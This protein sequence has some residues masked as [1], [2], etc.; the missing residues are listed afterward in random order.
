MLI[1]LQNYFTVDVVYLWLN[2][3]VL[4]LWL[5]LIFFPNSRM[6]KI[7]I[8]SI[9]MPIVFSVTYAYITYIFIIQSDSIFEISNFYFGI[10]NLYSLL[11]DETFLLIFWIHF[12]SLNLFLGSWTSRDATKYGVSKVFTGFCLIL[13]Y[14]TGPLG[15]VLYWLIRI[16]YS[17][18]FDLY[19]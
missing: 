14:L 18:K 19:D 12:I 5:A 7:F 8:T 9:F 13:I 4:P 15:L 6:V 11:S 1:N 3:G 17:K 16:F 10:D 2:F